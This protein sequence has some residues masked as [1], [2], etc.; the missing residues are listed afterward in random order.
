MRKPLILW[1]TLAFAIIVAGFT[2]W[3]PQHKTVIERAED[4]TLFVS[5]F[6]DS[7]KLALDWWKRNKLTLQQ[8]YNLIPTKGYFSLTIMDFGKGYVELP[9]EDFIAGISQDDYLCFDSIKNKKR[10]LKKEVMA[11]IAGDITK[12]V[13]I[14]IGETEYIQYPDGTIEKAK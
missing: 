12:K 6:P 7:D 9:A 3:S 14:Y 2:F 5:N 8:R 11:S 1:P 4:G 13:F 10:C